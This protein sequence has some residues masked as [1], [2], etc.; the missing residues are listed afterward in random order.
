MQLLEAV[1]RGGGDT[2][3][4]SGGGGG[5]LVVANDVH[6][7]RARTLVGQ[8]DERRL[9][10]FG[11]MGAGNGGEASKVEGLHLPGQIWGWVVWGGRRGGRAVSRLREGVLCRGWVT[12]GGWTWVGGWVGSMWV[13]GG[14]WLAMVDVGGVVLDG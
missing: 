10:R 13:G 14:V 9:Q 4:G 2:G 3:G 8:R 6:P 5:G 11:W 7:Q 12:V 1:C